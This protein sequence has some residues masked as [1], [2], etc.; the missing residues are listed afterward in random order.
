MDKW[1]NDLLANVKRGD[2]DTFTK[3]TMPQTA[4]GYG[5]TEAPRGA[6]GHWVDIKG[7]KI[8]NYQ[9]IVP[10]TW[11]GSPRD[12]KGHRGAI[13]EALVGTPVA[14][15]KKPLELLRTI[16]SFDPCLACAVHVIDPH[17]NE[18]YETKVS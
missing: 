6:L 13:E 14:D 8:H 4:K 3:F 9:M 18:V 5:M 1:M 11:N 10:T 16:H 7:G 12:K 17:T 2:L 15:P